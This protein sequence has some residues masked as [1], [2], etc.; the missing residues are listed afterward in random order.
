MSDEDIKELVR[1]GCF[2]A[3]S[4]VVD[5]RG[6]TGAEATRLAVDAALRMLLDNG[7]ISIAPRD[8]WPEWTEI[9]RWRVA[10]ES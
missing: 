3:D 1:S 6:C 2:A 9:D 4:V 5:N 8:Q 7:M 10:G